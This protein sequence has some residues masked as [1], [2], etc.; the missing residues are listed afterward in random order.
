M[1]VTYNG[2]KILFVHVGGNAGTS[3]EWYLYTLNR[4]YADVL[5]S[6]HSRGAFSYK[7]TIRSPEFIRAIG[8]QHTSLEQHLVAGTEFDVSFAV[9]RNPYDRILSKFF[10]SPHSQNVNE[11]N[12]RELFLSFIR[13]VYTFDTFF[14]RDQRIHTQCQSKMIMSG[15]EE[16]DRVLMYESLQS[17]LR[18]F[19]KD[20]NL[21]EKQLV[22]CN[23]TDHPLKSDDLYTDQGREIVYNYNQDI[24]D[25]YYA[26][27]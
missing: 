16:V 8:S 6:S 11:N 12:A 17:D 10:T 23:S 22:H 26:H 2:H 5:I 25:Q 9:I 15:N 14:A 7:D 18:E 1:V 20:Y 19:C 3:V 27:V 13:E 4:P 24:I 21:P